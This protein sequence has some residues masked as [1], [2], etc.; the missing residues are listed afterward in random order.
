MPLPIR[1]L[2]WGI[3]HGWSGRLRSRFFGCAVVNSLAR[4]RTR[5][6]QTASPSS[7]VFFVGMVEARGDMPVQLFWDHRVMDALELERLVREIEVILNN[8]IVAELDAS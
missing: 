4:P 7:F 8:E 6:L 3:A 1:R 5:I 2:I